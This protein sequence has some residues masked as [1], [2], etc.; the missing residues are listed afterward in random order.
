LAVGF[1]NLTQFWHGYA[2]KNIAFTILA[3]A[4]FKKMLGDCGLAF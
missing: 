4:G 1:G 3:S 2:Q